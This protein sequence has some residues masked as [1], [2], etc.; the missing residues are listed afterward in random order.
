MIDPLISVADLAA[1]L[2]G[3][4]P[5]RV[6]D[7]TW[8]FPGGPA[9]AMEGS[10]A[11][12]V[13]FDIDVL[14]DLDDPRPHMMPAPAVFAAALARLGLHPDAP[15]VAYDRIGLFSAPRAWWM[16]RMIGFEDVRVLDGGLP[17][18]AA[19]G[20]VVSPQPAA[21]TAPTPAPAFAPRLREELVMDAERIAA[22]LSGGETALHI[23][24]ARSPGR[25]AGE[26]AEPRPG[27]RPGHI[28]GARNTPYRAF[29][30]NDGAMKPPDALRATL[31]QAGV[32]LDAPTLVTSCG[33]GVTASLAALALA[34]VG[35]ADAAV[36]D[37]S[38]ADWGARA[39]LPVETGPTAPRR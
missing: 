15:V 31:A 19:A 2:S 38:W 39:D 35:R 10:I 9:V 7:A 22:A 32:D 37:G 17:A 11:G 6:I 5:P 8:T 16:L 27:V 1:A 18:W 36:Y 24:D 26:E 23:L 28:P 21:A 29:L 33:S 25:F 3:S 30:R 14:R 34:R 20:E 4:T 12:A 13:S